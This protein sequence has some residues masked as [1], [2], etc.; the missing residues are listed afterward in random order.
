MSKARLKKFKALVEPCLGDL[1]RAA[2]RLTGNATD[3]ED[4]VQD[5]CLRAWE[6]FPDIEDPAHLKHWLL[7]VI[8]HRFVDGKRRDGFVGMHSLNQS[9]ESGLEFAGGEPDPESQALQLERVLRID[10]ACAALDAEQ[11]ALLVLRAEGYRLDEIEE[12]TGI[13]REAVS[14]RLYRARRRLAVLLR[15][16][17]DPADQLVEHGRGQ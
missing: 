2:R 14:A 5:C 4:L 12:I 7:R 11:Y 9:E 13:A 3:A 17:S 15:E 10:R 8:Y 6:R 1:Y 16:A